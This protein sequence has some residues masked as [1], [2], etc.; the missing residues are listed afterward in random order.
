MCDI[1]LISIIMAAYNA[2]KTIEMAIRSV[3]S[4]S[5]PN[6]ELIVINDCSKDATVSIVEQFSD[7]RIRL[8][9]NPVNRGVSYTRHRGVEEARGQ[10]IAILDSD[11]AWAPDKLEKQVQC[12]I[13]K[14][15]DLLF[16]ASSFMNADGESIDWILHAPE[17]M[18][19]RTL[20]KQNLVSNSS[21]LVRKAI[22]AAH[23]RQGDGMHEDFATWLSILKTGVKA[24]G[25]DEPLLIY[26]ISTTSKTGNKLKAARMNWNTYRAVGLNIF[27]AG[28]YMVWYTINGLKKYKNL[29]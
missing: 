28:Y 26:R 11:D 18:D 27:V 14:N 13:E 1:G 15:A 9:C 23:E 5:Y 17:E 4:Q 22:Y 7:P 16:T 6:W 21:V 8:V 2:E 19:Y 20:L 3:L 29:K 24:Y 12:Q 10:W 25:I